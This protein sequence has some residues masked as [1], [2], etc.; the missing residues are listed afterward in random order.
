MDELGD[1][2]FKT[3]FE[4]CNATQARE[5]VDLLKCELRSL[6]NSSSRI[7]HVEIKNTRDNL[8]EA[9]FHAEDITSYKAAISAITRYIDIISKTFRLT[10]QD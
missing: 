4:T 5:Y 3:W 2:H 10:H 8:V 7:N 6:E 1:F 9:Y